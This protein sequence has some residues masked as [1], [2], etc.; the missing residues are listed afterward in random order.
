MHLAVL[1]FVPPNQHHPVHLNPQ[2]PSPAEDDADVLFPVLVQLGV[3]G[4]LG[5]PEALE[6]PEVVEAL[7]VTLVANQALQGVSLAIPVD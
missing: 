3:Q 4:V 2:T 1:D 5:V 7:L 6:L